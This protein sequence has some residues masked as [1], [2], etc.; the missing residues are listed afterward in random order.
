[1]KK[2]KVGALKILEQLG[3]HRKELR[4]WAMYDW[5]ITGMW[6][7]VVATLFP[8]YFQTRL[9]NE[10]APALATQH[11]ATATTLGMVIIAVISPFLGAI[12][13]YLPVKKKLL[14]VFALVG[15]SSCLL[16]ITAD[17]GQWQLGLALFVLINLGA[18]GSTVFYDAML[19]H[20]ASDEEMDRVSSGGFAVGYL[21]AGLLLSACLLLL[22]FSENLG[23]E[24]GSTL[25]IRLCFVAV[26]AWWFLFSIPLFKNVSEPKPLLP[27]QGERILGQ[28][29]K[30][31]LRRLLATI[32]DL[33]SRKE[34][35]LMLIAFLIYNDGISTI[36]R[37]AA[38][39]G[40]EIGLDQSVLMG[41]IVMVQFVGVPCTFLF[42]MV[43]GKIGTR[44][45]IFLGL[46][47][48]LVIS[49]LA[50]FMSTAA[51]FFLLGFLVGLVQG[52]TQGLSRS[53]FAS[54]IPRSKSG[55]F[56]GFF[57]VVQK[58]SG[59]AGPA[60][61]AVVIANTGSSALGILSI[62]GFFLIGGG[63]LALVNVDEGRK[64]AR[65]EEAKTIAKL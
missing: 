41:T 35:F 32:S 15:I 3:L 49:A 53:L 56:F 59:I 48:Y 58:F 23:F 54:M 47:L 1:M 10:L 16:L 12:T 57:A 63:L 28:A 21:G 17:Q 39:Y 18:N 6:A 45:A 24:A 29:I 14:A 51:H 60:V 50:Y 61:I 8:I 38:I 42:G 37:M 2:R 55:E 43:A 9:A 62:S 20:I 27:A 25:P 4:A 36:I 19:P 5:A 11:F 7:V 13:D 31:A 40:A 34:A 44:K 46:C 33:R 52:G 65:L 30:G 64:A 22:T 26:G